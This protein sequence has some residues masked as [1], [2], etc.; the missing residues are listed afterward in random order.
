MEALV[1]VRKEVK[2]GRTDTRTL[3]EPLISEQLEYSRLYILFKTSYKSP[4]GVPETAPKMRSE[5]MKEDGFFTM[6]RS[7]AM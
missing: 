7:P 6:S 1:F 4:R 3:I 5:G 2:N